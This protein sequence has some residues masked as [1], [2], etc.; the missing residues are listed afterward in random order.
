MSTAL[1]DP[2]S[3]RRT[4]A[5]SRS[6]RAASPSGILVALW[7]FVV[8]PF[9][10]LLA[11]VPVAWGWLADL[12]RRRHRRW[13][14]TWS[15]GSASPSAS[16]AT[17]R[18]ARSRPSAGCGSRWPSPARWRSRA[19]RPSGSPTTA[20]TTRSPTWRATRTRRGATASSFWGLT[21]GLFYAHVGWLF[22]RELS[23]RERF[24][25]DLLADQDIRRVDKLFPRARGRLA[26]R[27]GA[28]R[29][30]GHLVL[31]GRAD[32]VLLGR[33]GPHR[34]AAPRHLV[35]QLGLPRLRRAPVRHRQG[36]KAANFWPLA[37]LSF[38]ESWHNLHHADPTCARHG[39]LRGQIDINARLIWIFEKFGWGYATCAGRSRTGSPRSWSKPATV[40]VTGDAPDRWRP[41]TGWHGW[42]G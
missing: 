29:R 21:K 10:A 40:A 33:P 1:L 7:A 15:P 30:P 23:N 35:D 26:A 12:D 6:P 41:A 32:R 14:S 24:A 5:P 13:S 3:H 36:D 28:D 42:R 38:G 31:A 11:A 39:V 20:A 18:T 22:H 34:A 27:P 19:H 9:V 8:I 4:A 16:T 2:P 25:P 37:I 17:S